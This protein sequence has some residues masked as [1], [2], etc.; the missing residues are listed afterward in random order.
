MLSLVNSIFGKL[1][2]ESSCQLN[3]ILLCGQFLADR[4]DNCCC[5]GSFI[6]Q[7]GEAI[8]CL[9][10]FFISVNGAVEGSIMGWVS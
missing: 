1:T 9:P 10:D 7:D 6:E 2:K 4:V 3:I 8:N 5:A